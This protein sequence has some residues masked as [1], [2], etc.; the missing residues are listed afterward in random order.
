MGFSVLWYVSVASFSQ[1][2]EDQVLERIKGKGPCVNG[3]KCHQGSPSKTFEAV[4]RSGRVCPDLL[5]LSE[6][7]HHHKMQ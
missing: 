2:W 7:S 3:G 6:I 1:T 5:M 4:H